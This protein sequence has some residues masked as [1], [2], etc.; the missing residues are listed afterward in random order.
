[1]QKE[2]NSLDSDKDKDKHQQ[3]EFTRK[4]ILAMIIAM[5]KV[6]L[7][8]LFII[9]LAFVVVIYLMLRFWLN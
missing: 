1:M 3:Q 8:Q 4:D 5:Y 7:P 9:G 2:R 6:I